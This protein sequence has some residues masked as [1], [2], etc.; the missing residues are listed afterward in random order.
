LAGDT[1]KR[2]NVKY[3]L[4]DTG[5]S[6]KLQGV[7]QQLKLNQAEL[8]NAQVGMSAFGKS[9]SSLKGVQQA[10]AT[11]IETQGKK[12][13]IYRQSLEKAQSK[14]ESNVTA[15]DR[16]KTSL[17]QE[18]AKLEGATSAY[19][20]NSEVTQ[21][22]KARV[23]ELTEQY[24]QQQKAVENSAKSVVNSTTNMT[25]AETELKRLQGELSKANQELAKSQSGWINAGKSLESSSQKFKTL[26]EGANK[27]G[28]TLLKFS[29]PLVAGLA[30][31]TKSAGDFEHQLADIRKEVVASG[32]PVAQVNELMAQMSKNSIQWSE[33]FGQSTDSINEGLLT[34]VKDGYSADESMKIM[35]TSLYTA[36]GANEDLA[37]VVDQLG[38]SLE[39]Y[40]MKTD[41][42][43]QT[44]QNMSH[45]ADS[46]AYISNH[47]KASISSLGEAFSTAGSTAHA[48]GIPM[49]QTA[50][51]IGILESNGVDASTA[52]N[53]LKAGLVNLT[54][55]TD[56]MAAAMKEMGLKVFD[57]KGNMKDLPTILNDIEKGTAKWTNEQKQAAIATIFGKESL[58]SWNILVHK[59]GDYLGDLSNHANNATGEV[60]H[61]SDSMKDTPVNQFNELKESVH[62]L[63]VTFGEEVLPTIMPLVKGA[64]NLVKEFGNLD[65]G[66]KKVIVG[67]AGF[68]LA[69][70]TS[71]K[72]VG[73]LAGSIGNILGL[74]GRFSTA[75]GTAKVAVE[76][77]S[78]AAGVAET[79][80]AGVGAATVGATAGA[81]G[82]AVGFGT[83]IIAAAPWLL[84]AAGVVAA[85]I[86]IHHVLTQQATPAVDLFADKVTTTSKVATDNYGMMS[87][88]IEQHTTKISNSTKQA[89]G[90]Y[91]KMDDDVKKTLTD[92]YVNST[93]IT[94]QNKN[95]LVGKYQQ[96]TT[97]IKQ[98]MDKHYNDE[99]T[100]LQSFFGKSTALNAQEEASALAKLQADNNNKKAS[101]D[102]YEQQI[103]A[104]MQN[105]LNNHRSLTDQEQQQINSI[106]DKMRSNAVN[107]LSENEV[108]AKVIMERMKDYGT[109]IT[110]QQASQIIQNANKQRDGAVNSANSQYN[111][112]VSAIIRARDESHSI[113]AD[114]A[115]KL[116]AD[117]K[118]QRDDTVSH[119]EN[120][121]SQVVNKVSSMNSSVSQ[122]VNTTTGNIFTKWDKLKNWWNDWK[123]A[124]KTF[125]ANV[126]Q[127]VV[128]GG[129]IPIG[130][131]ATGDS[132]YGGGLTT[133]HEKGYEVYNLPTGTRIY[134]HEASEDLVKKTAESVASKVAS[135][136]V[137][138][139]GANGTAV[140]NVYLDSNKLGTYMT[141][142][143]SN[144]IAKASIR[145]RY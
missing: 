22:A 106:Q 85:G 26:G 50:A 60:K 45:M 125:A 24:N 38:S 140:T 23:A 113:T 18:K 123:P 39:A 112:T 130:A 55:P 128:S 28:N 120:M 136:M 97:Q 21:N 78:V 37:T 41:N 133:L 65:D 66:T 47:T 2:I 59:G 25:K 20:K 56:A 1:E 43:A 143:I 99:Y 14:M 36:R 111:S 142:I 8:K 145:R 35:Q 107:S 139:N 63:G 64:T 49:T 126:L 13:D 30:V 144:N 70:G 32:I 90:A 84:L 116:I 82:L 103:Q 114:Q 16:I 42:A 119:A 34:L 3:I 71:L 94:E 88:Q 95:A 132:N 89:V 102:S 127:N 74:L 62:A 51:A 104:I 31:A 76:G 75:I 83:L 96:M 68:A 109:N 134:N 131:R 12:V 135:Q 5:Y 80:T 15:R 100:S 117:A 138:N 108:Q 19:G 7:N 92:L 17:D 6:G 91:I 10:L 27:V 101:I 4:D 73:G 115:N 98:G 11:Q 61:L 58:S 81:G 69:A 53:S 141:P 40:G 48:M 118:R 110:A 29:A 72:V 121:R 9:S 137:N 44:T 86:G 79:A 67:V 54:K 87:T 129:N 93:T 105:A 33:D 57:A 77:A 124:I 52:A 46:F 122:N